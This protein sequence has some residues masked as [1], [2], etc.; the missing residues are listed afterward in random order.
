MAGTRSWTGTVRRVMV[1]AAVAVLAATLGAVA[2]PLGPPAP[3][4]LPR[5]AFVA[6]DDIPFD[7]LGVGPVAGALGGI[8]AIT[9]SAE[10]STPAIRTLQDFDP[11]VVYLAGGPLALSD[12]VAEEVADVCA[13]TPRRLD[14]ADRRETARLI[15]GILADLGV[16]RPLLTGAQVE[17][18][19]HLGGHLAV[20]TLSVHDPA[21]PLVVVTR[22]FRSM[23]VSDPE[24][25]EVWVSPTRN[26]VTIEDNTN[27]F[28]P[29]G[30]VAAM[31]DIVHAPG[32][33]LQLV[34]A[35]L[36]FRET[37]GGDVDDVFITLERVTDMGATETVGHAVS[38][39]PG[40]SGCR[41]WAIPSA[42]A[43]SNTDRAFV[44]GPRDYVHFTAGVDL[45]GGNV[46]LV[47]AS[48]TFDRLPAGTPPMT[49]V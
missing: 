36:C 5:I 22:D 3:D 30:P 4:P 12:D 18:D 17:G 34:G 33:V 1:L 7:A 14:G 48:L 47:S 37:A 41:S 24:G 15:A 23:R 38:A 9:N 31:F 21:D 8:V 42:A 39:D 46:A 35:E 20:D 32:E 11:E 43:N 13:C 25:P 26:Q 10:L 27:E 29:G 6:R 40:T 44:M 19:A 16:G 2:A 28:G 45:T 49:P